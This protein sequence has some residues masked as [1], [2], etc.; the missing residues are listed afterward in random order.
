MNL[1][2][3]CNKKTLLY[4][5]PKSLFIACMF[6]ISFSLMAPFKLF[7][8]I[9]SYSGCHLKL[10]EDMCLLKFLYEFAWVKATYGINYTDACQPN[11]KQKNNTA[12][13]KSLCHASLR[14][15]EPNP[16]AIRIKI[17]PTQFIQ[18]SMQSYFREGINSSR[19][20]DPQLFGYRPSL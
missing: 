5:F 17:Q 18:I 14:I 20:A 3:N 16:F 13:E 7:F 11:G 1:Q 2:C 6:F 15:K 12:I 9:L 8:L 19:A 4:I 10:I